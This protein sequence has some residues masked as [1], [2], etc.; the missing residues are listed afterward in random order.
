[1]HLLSQEYSD[2]I[3]FDTRNVLSYK[4]PKVFD[5]KYDRNVT[6]MLSYK[7]F[8]FDLPFP[9]SQKD[10]NYNYEQFILKIMPG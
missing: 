10:N 9:D 5:F 8:V 7:H 3:T 1:M 4:I 2:K 6:F